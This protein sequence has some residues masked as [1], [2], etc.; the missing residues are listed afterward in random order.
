[1]K[2]KIILFLIFLIS[3]LAAETIKENKQMNE[4]RRPLYEK[5]PLIRDYRINQPIKGAIRWGTVF[6]FS[7]ELI[8]SRLN[9][10]DSKF[11]N[12]TSHMG[13]YGLLGGAI[14]GLVQG[15]VAHNKKKVNPEYLI[16]SNIFGYELDAIIKSTGENHFM[17]MGNRYLT[18]DYKYRFID[19]I[20]FGL[21]WSRFL[22]KEENSF[23]YREWKYDLQGLHYYR[24]GSFFSP[25]YVIGCG[26]SYGKRLD[27]EHDEDDRKMISQRV[28]PFA[29]SAVGI[30]F[31]FFDF[32]F[33]KV[34]ADFELSSFYWYVNS[35]DKYPFKDNLGI[36][37]ALCTKIF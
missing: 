23:T 15:Y 4:S 35:F 1:M 28:L 29:H 36:G 17:A 27:N 26:L 13:E 8:N 25:F 22:D 37:I 3:L 10:K 5:V 2:V 6:S 30:R 31:S 9:S 21:A 24:K 7:G 11:Y 14:L 16:Q 20:Q 19:E 33:L 34:K 32:F 18:Y 12:F